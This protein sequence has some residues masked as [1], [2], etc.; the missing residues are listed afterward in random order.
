MCMRKK[1]KQS[2]PRE[3]MPIGIV[4]A[5]GA[6][7]VV[8]ASQLDTIRIWWNE[9]AGDEAE[10]V[11]H[12]RPT[13]GEMKH[14]WTGVAQGYEQSEEMLEPVIQH[15]SRLG[16]S[17]VRIDHVFDGYE[18]VERK[19]EGLRM[20]F[21]RLDRTVRAIMA[22]GARPAFALSYMA[23]AL[24]AQGDI[25]GAPDN[26]QEWRFVVKGLIEHYSGVE[27]MGLDNVYYE[28][29]NEPDLFGEWKMQAGGKSYLELYKQTA[30][31][32][33]EV[34]RSKPFLL[35][36]PGTTGMYPNWVTMLVTEARENNWQLDFVSWHRYSSDVADFTEDVRWVNRWLTRTKNKDLKLVI[37]EWGHTSANDPGYDTGLAAAHGVSVI[38]AI[39]D[40]VEHA[41]AFELKDGRDPLNKQFWGRWGMITHEEA[42]T[43]P[44]PRYRAWRLL[45][46]LGNERLIVFGEGTWV[47][48]MATAKGEG[49]S[50]IITNY[51]RAGVHREVVPIT[52]DRLPA[53]TYQWRVEDSNAVVRSGTTEVVSEWTGSLEM[54]PNVVAL[55]ELRKL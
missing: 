1:W 16:V 7:A 36:G 21:E 29:W 23:P 44:K 32:A 55:L 53:G 25:T 5:L 46:Q 28:V 42:G 13:A 20:N 6:L 22:M 11:V 26:W 24:N 18:L 19:S 54:R 10:L 15:G 27:G 39:S 8:I 51:D 37:S 33:K 31:A 12:Y 50:M 30:Q 3:W 47:K 45:N 49:V 4:L 14:V 35:G 40:Q 9:A 43:V 38:R 52:V 17:I 2:Q 41:W 34:R 48:A